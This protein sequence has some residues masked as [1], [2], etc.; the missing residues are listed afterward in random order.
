MHSWQRGEG[1][2]LTMTKTMTNED[3]KNNN[4]DK[5]EDKVNV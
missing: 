4:E 5:L 1:V 2:I 3:D